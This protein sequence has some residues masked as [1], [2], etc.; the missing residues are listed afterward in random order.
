[1]QMLITEDRITLQVKEQQT[2]RFM[3]EMKSRQYYLAHTGN[4]QSSKT[5]PCS[6]TTCGAVI[7]KLLTAWTGKPQLALAF[8]LTADMLNINKGKPTTVGRAGTNTLAIL[9]A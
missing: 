2:N 1:M 6:F 4:K 3:P 5:K 7:P 8:G 9:A